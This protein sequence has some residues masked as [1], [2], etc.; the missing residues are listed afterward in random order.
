[1][2]SNLGILCLNT[3]ARLEEV[4]VCIFSLNLRSLDTGLWP[5]SR[6][7]STL[8]VNFR[9]LKGFEKHKLD[10]IMKCYS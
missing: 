9:T 6:L 4:Q 1:M 5:V 2:M 10:C 8:R 7:Q 3:L